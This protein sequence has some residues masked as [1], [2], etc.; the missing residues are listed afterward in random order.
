MDQYGIGISLYF[1]FMSTMSYAFIVAGIVASVSMTYYWSTSA[2]TD[3]EKSS[4]IA[5]GGNQRFVFFTSAGSL[6]GTYFTCGSGFEGDRI[7]LSCGQGQLQRIEAYFGEP[8]GECNCPVDQSILPS[9]LQCP[10]RPDYSVLAHGECSQ[11]YAENSLSHAKGD[12]IPCFRGRMWTGEACCT[13]KLHKASLSPDL[14]VLAATPSPGCNSASA[15]YIVQAACLQASNCTFSVNSNETYSWDESRKSPC[16]DGIKIW[17]PARS[18]FVCRASLESP[19]SNFTTCSGQRRL[20]VRGRCG[21]GEFTLPGYEGKQTRAEWA[22]FLSALDAFITLGIFIVVLWLA[23]KELAA[24][25]DF[26]MGNCSVNDYTLRVVFL[27]SPPKGKALNLDGLRKSL[28]DHFNDLCNS[29]VAPSQ[30]PDRQDSRV[31]VVDV[32]LG[33]NNQDVIKDMKVRG[34]LAMLLDLEAEK[35]LIMTV[36]GFLHSTSE[37]DKQMH[38]VRVVKVRFVHAADKCKIRSKPLKAQTAF[39]T[40]DSEEGFERAKSVYHRGFFGKLL[41]R[42]RCCAPAGSYYKG[43]HALDIKECVR[44]SDYLWENFSTPPLIKLAK[45]SI[46]NLL[47]LGILVIGFSIIIKAKQVE[48]SA[49]LKIASN[50]CTIYEFRYSGDP[51]WES[52]LNANFTHGIPKPPAS[53]TA[54]RLDVAEHYYSGQFNNSAPDDSMLTCFCMWLGAEEEYAEDAPKV[55]FLNPKTN[56]KELL[57]EGVFEDFAT[58]QIMATVAAL[59]VTVTNE[60]LK[61]TFSTLVEFEGHETLTEKILAHCLKLFGAMFMNTAIIVI[62]ISGNLDYFTGGEQG[63]VSRRLWEVGIFSGDI[64]DFDA[65]WYLHVGSAICLTVYANTIAVNFKV[66]KDYG[67]TL[68][69]RFADRGYSSDYSRTSSKLQTELEALYTGPLMNLEERYAS[70][71]VIYFVCI[72]FSSG[73]PMLWAVGGFS[74]L[75]S[76]TVEKWAFLRVYRIPPAYGPSLARFCSDILP[77]GVLFHAVIASWTFSAPSLFDYLDSVVEGFDSNATADDVEHAMAAQET[78]ELA[79]AKSLA[80]FR[81]MVGAAQNGSNI[82]YTNASFSNSSFRYVVHNE[83]GSAANHVDLWAPD[84]I[85]EFHILKPILRVALHR[86]FP[87]QAILL[88]IWVVWFVFTKVINVDDLI[89]SSGNNLDEAE[90]AGDVPMSPVAIKKTKKPP[91][92]DVV[93]K[94]AGETKADPEVGGGAPSSALQ[95]SSDESDTN[96]DL[97]EGDSRSCADEWPE[98]GG[99]PAS[100]VDDDEEGGGG[101]DKTKKKNKKKNRHREGDPLGEETGGSSSGARAAPKANAL[102]GITLK[103]GGGRS[104]FMWGRSISSVDERPILVSDSDCDLHERATDGPGG[105]RVLGTEQRNLRPSEHARFYFEAKVSMC[106]FGAGPTFISRCTGIKAFFFARLEVS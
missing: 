94:A 85:E 36:R 10:A 24:I 17:D 81:S 89:R 61:E 49:N 104:A 47:A 77:L 69:I 58:V 45:V 9:T 33:L 48:K 23:E 30:I 67:K 22:E 37:V 64:A 72:L 54:S 29:A 95:D 97:E 39:I 38:R 106:A 80:A 35:L 62:L 76:S 88:A 32:N 25:E 73:I 18:K 105:R 4:W 68:L 79:E 57:C 71:L 65:Q 91:K 26:D 83:I 92:V 101:E 31:H 40:F 84:P 42:C 15:E 34:K 11:T 50:D 82:S 13:S 16:G 53:V 102:K 19:S 56:K 5:S 70:M 90:D 59:T 2:W 21:V 27:P 78:F 52:A 46:S 75:W 86:N 87:P 20:L 12:P 66:I 100:T 103:G 41:G 98:V 8:E 51:H 44:P 43:K 28:A 99:A 63:E 96:L 6:G 93:P 55:E 3:A 14:D 74:F 7:T 60:M 1:K